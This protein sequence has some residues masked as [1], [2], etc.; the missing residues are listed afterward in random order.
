MGV[1]VWPLPKS[2]RS[3]PLEGRLLI[4]PRLLRWQK[5]NDTGRVSTPICITIQIGL[6][7]N[8]TRDTHEAILRGGHTAVPKRIQLPLSLSVLSARPLQI[9]NT[10]RCLL[11]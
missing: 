10:L 3:A 1:A 8:G 2:H 11:S 5:K 4:Y 9:G 7:G 6:D